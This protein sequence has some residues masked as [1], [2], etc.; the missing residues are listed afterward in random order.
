MYEEAVIEAQKVA[1]LEKTG[2]DGSIGYLYAVSRHR[3][4]ALRALQ[5]LH[6]HTRINTGLAWSIWAWAIRIELSRHTRPA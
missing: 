6:D 3:D 5:R 1:Q 4:E 2:A